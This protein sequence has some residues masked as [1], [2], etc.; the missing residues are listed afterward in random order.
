MRLLRGHMRSP[1]GWLAERLHSPCAESCHPIRCKD[2]PRNAPF[3]HFRLSSVCPVAAP[4]R[5][6][7]RFERVPCE[8]DCRHDTAMPGPNLRLGASASAPPGHECCARAL[9]AVRWLAWLAG[10]IAPSRCARGASGLPV[11]RPRPR[12]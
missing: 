8:R 11:L 12:K 10:G 1:P 2:Q 7:T 9:Y 6:P 3:S 5:P 4:P